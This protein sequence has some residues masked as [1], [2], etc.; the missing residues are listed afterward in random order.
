MHRRALVMA[1]QGVSSLSNVIVA[2]MVARSVSAAEFGAFGLAMITYSLALGMSR[3][4]IG[5]PLLSRHSHEGPEAR[6]RLAPAMVGAMLTVSA[7]AAPVVASVGLLLSGSAGSALTAL[8]LVLPLVL[9]QDMWR[10]V[11]VV[12]RPA[13]ALAIDVVWLVAVGVALAQAPSDAGVAW[14]VVAWGLAG[15]LGAVVAIAMGR[16]SPGA[17]RPLVWLSDQ[18]AWSGRFL[19]EWASAELSGNVTTL[20]LGPIAGLPA[21]GAVRGVQT[22]YGPLNTIHTGIYLGVVPEGA[23][24]R[25]DPERLYRLMVRVTRLIV[26]A[27]ALWMIICIALP[28]A[29]GRSLFGDTWARGSEL[30]LPMGLVVIA[31]SSSMGGFA[32]IRSLG[33]PQASLRARLLSVPGEMVL[34]IAGAVLGGAA[35]FV[36]GLFAGRVLTRTIWWREFRRALSRRPAA[37]PPERAETAMEP[38][39][40]ADEALSP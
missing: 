21:L 4:V 40:A 25:D 5:D 28:D 26:A 33:Q 17:I 16:P 35:G 37:G 39:P 29:Q 31:G 7:V 3:S 38:A 10:Y 15:G 13:R 22:L 12:D 34:P 9:L 8:A 27:A 36:W 30:I 24:L 14:Y 23:H 11:F 19:G 32:G 1:D 6:A 2:V 18:R 20:T